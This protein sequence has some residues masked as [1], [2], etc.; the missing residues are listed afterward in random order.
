M[1]ECCFS[2]QQLILTNETA[3][4]CFLTSISQCRDISSLR[5]QFALLVIQFSI[6]LPREKNHIWS[7]DQR[8]KKKEKPPCGGSKRRSVY[9]KVEYV[10][11]LFVSWRVCPLHVHPTHNPN[12]FPGL[13]NQPLC[14]IVCWFWLIIATVL[15]AMSEFRQISMKSRT[16]EGNKF[17][18]VPVERSNPEVSFKCLD[19]LPNEKKWP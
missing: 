3:E 10:Q 6:N 9:S 14:H 7:Y 5:K 8:K 16:H 2:H 15:V 11:S 17:K 19:Y 1:F 18:L 12:E 13:Q 4:K